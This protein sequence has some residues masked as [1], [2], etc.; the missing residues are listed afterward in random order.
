MITLDNIIKYCPYFFIIFQNYYINILKLRKELFMANKTIN[1]LTEL[2]SFVES[3]EL[4]IYDVSNDLTTKGSIK[5]LFKTSLT[6][7]NTT[8]KNLIGA[9]NEV[10]TSGGGDGEALTPAVKTALLALAQEM[11]NQDYSYS[12]MLYDAFYP[13]ENVRSLQ[14][15]YTQSEN[16]SPGSE[17]SDLKKDLVVTVTY[18]NNYSTTLT[19][20]QYFL[21]GV[22]YPGTSTITVLYQG[23][24]A[25]F[26]VNVATVFA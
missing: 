9:I 13:S 15:E 2:T 8:S 6:D 23:H 25:T 7:L 14:V 26:N 1:E 11:N 12:K 18:A 17:L 21:G 19:Q 24:T 16:V 20:T 5:N 10:A 4:A 3:D 22:L